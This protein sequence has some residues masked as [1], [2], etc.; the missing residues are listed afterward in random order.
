MTEKI[1]SGTELLNRKIREF[2]VCRIKKGSSREM[3]KGERAGGVKPPALVFL[4]IYISTDRLGLL[5]ICI[6][7]KHTQQTSFKSTIDSV[8][9]THLTLPTIYSV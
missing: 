6:F 8:S 3:V 2:H 4:A 1:S 9:Y 7:H 5:E